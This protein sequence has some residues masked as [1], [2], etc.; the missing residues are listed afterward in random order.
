MTDRP[1]HR[2]YRV[3]GIRPNGQR[4]QMGHG[5]TSEEAK[6]IRESLIEAN[7]FGGITVEVDTGTDRPS[8]PTG[9][10]SPL[11]L[12]LFSK[13]TVSGKY[14][15]YPRMCGIAFPIRTGIYSSWFSIR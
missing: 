3:V 9:Q 8:G 11:P 6:R 12:T 7:V 15:H 13:V 1:S 4:V 14:G 5:L 2:L 10:Y